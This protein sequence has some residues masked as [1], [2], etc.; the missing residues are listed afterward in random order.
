MENQISI[1]SLCG[2]EARIKVMSTQAGLD[3]NE[4]YAEVWGVIESISEKNT[5]KEKRT[6]IVIINQ[7]G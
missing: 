1:N 5:E 7:N 3:G 6:V 4:K 2:R